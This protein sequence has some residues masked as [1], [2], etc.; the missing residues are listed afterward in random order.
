MFSSEPRQHF[1]QEAS[2]DKLEAAVARN[3]ATGSPARCSL[4]VSC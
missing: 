1:L 3:H 2:D 4:V